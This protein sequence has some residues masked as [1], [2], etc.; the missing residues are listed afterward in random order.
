MT[1]RGKLIIVSGPSG[2]GKGT[3]LQELFRLNEFPLVAS[4]SAT[5]RPPRQGEL[6][7]V[8]YHFLSKEDFLSRRDGNEFLESFNV[9]SKGHWYGTL[10]SE[11]ENGLAQGAWVVLEIDVQGMKEVLK[12]YPDALTV[13]ILPPDEQILRQRLTH[14]GTEKPAELEKRL[15][16]AREEI[17]QSNECRC[18]IVN[19]TVPEAVNDFRNF[20]NSSR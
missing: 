13:F 4:V 15:A 2:V 3:I 18:R 14:R 8:N 9:F 19:D 10:R 7:G 1:E 20:L 17:Q 16:T 5:T 11:V 6:T 12:S